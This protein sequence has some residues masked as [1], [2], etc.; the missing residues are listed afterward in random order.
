MPE[1]ILIE[2]LINNKEHGEAIQAKVFS[3]ALKI[4]NQQKGP[5]HEFNISNITIK[6][7]EGQDIIERF[8]KSFFIEKLNPE[9]SKTI[10]IGKYGSPMYGLVNIDVTTTPTDEAV[11][12]NL[13]QK[14]KY[15]MDASEIGKNKWTDF[16]YI[17]NSN[18]NKQE[19]TT[20]MMLLLAFI[21]AFFTLLQIASIFWI[22]PKKQMASTRSKIN[23]IDNLNFFVACQTKSAFK[24]DNQ[25]FLINYDSQIYKENFDTINKKPPSTRNAIINNIILMEASNK[26]MNLLFE[27]PQNRGEFSPKIT[28]NADEIIK[29]LGTYNKMGNCP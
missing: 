23:E 1:G 2:P 9:E 26:M 14:N 13:L 21:V 24:T 28:N 4:T 18:E 17:R 25:N 27:Q 15:T 16:L 8:N 3:F 11:I 22:E 12:L 10:V 29:N 7:A 19:R 20:N 6:S 5:S